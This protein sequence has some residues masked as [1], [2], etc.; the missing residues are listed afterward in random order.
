MS[1]FVDLQAPMGDEEKLLPT[2][3]IKPGD[4]I[5]GTNSPF[6]GLVLQEV[7]DPEM[8][9]RTWRLIDFRVLRLDCPSPYITVW[10]FAKD[11]QL[12]V[13]KG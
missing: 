7:D 12:R 2:G 9:G 1:R 13:I 11:G 6:I 3:E 4:I 8:P 10:A 5:C